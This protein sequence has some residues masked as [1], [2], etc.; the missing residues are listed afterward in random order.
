MIKF[1]PAV[2]VFGVYRVVFE[3]RAILD[4]NAY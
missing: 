3:D 1:F 4:K 2:A